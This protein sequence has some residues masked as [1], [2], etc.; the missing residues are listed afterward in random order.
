MDGGYSANP[1]NTKQMGGKRKTSM[2]ELKADMAVICEEQ[3]SLSGAS[4]KHISPDGCPFIGDASLSA[5]ELL[6]RP[7]CRKLISQSFCINSAFLE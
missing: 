5:T 1:D 3:N 2:R 4:S 7:A 6:A